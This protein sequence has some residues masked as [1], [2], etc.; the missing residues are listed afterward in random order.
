MFAFFRAF[1]RPLW[2]KVAT[3]LTF[4]HA[5][6]LG[7]LLVLRAWLPDLPPFLALANTALP[8]LFA[9]VLL[10][11]PLSWLVRSR[12]ACVTNL[13]T[14]ALFTSLYGAFF[15][16]RSLERSDRPADNIIVMTFNLGYGR[17]SADEVARAIRREGADLVTLQEVA[18]SVARKLQRELKDV[19]PYMHL[20]PGLARTGLLSRYPILDS[21]W[22]RPAGMKRPV[23]QATLDLTGFAG[24]RDLP[25]DLVAG[26]AAPVHV[27]VVHSKSPDL[28]WLGAWPLPTGLHDGWRDR[29]MAELAERAAA[30][31]GPVLVMGDFNM[32]DQTRGYARLSAVLKDAYREAGWGFGF[33]FPQGLRWGRW[34]VPGPLVRIDYVFHSPNWRADWARVGCEGS[35]DHC[36][37]VAGLIFENG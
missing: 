18:P 8:Y 29:Q 25:V 16:P 23:L 35:S 21:Q 9:P 4:A 22:F 30:L 26:S 28:S 6:A 32:T 24:L 14:L 31:E 17:A 34:P 2:S 11:L 15:F 10:A 27:L 36:Y 37:V 20:A 33:T 13:V 5:V 12:V 3:V 1:Q 19:Y 7:G